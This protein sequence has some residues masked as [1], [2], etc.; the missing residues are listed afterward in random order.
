[1]PTNSDIIYLT[2]TLEL[3]QIRRGFCAPNPSVGAII[4]RDANM[5]ATGYHYAP[6]HPHA[7]IDALKKINHQ[8]QGATLYVSLEPCCHHGRT[9]PCTDAIIQAGI[10]RVVYG[11]C[12]PNPLVSDKGA[13]ALNSAGISCEYLPLQQINEFYKSY[14]HWT[15]TKTPFITGKIA[16]SLDGKIA[17]KNGA[18]LQITGSELKEFTHA[19]RK[20]SDAILT[21]SNTIIKDNPQLNVRSQNETLSKPIYILDSQLNLPLIAQ[22]FT[23]AKTITVFHSKNAGDEKLKALTQ[24]GVRCISVEANEQGLNLNQIIQFIGQDGAHDLWIEA[25][26]KCFAAFAKERLLQ[27]AYL[28]I[29]PIILGEGLLAFDS[30]IEFSLTQAHWKQFG[31]DVLCELGLVDNLSLSS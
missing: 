15:Q 1:M 3:A 17:G 5:L 11:Y 20:T 13:E 23:T 18:P 10:K 9:P 16:L 31:K 21:T 24:Q 26:G 25:G 14:H 7:E 29:A 30:K 22:I 2:Q 8:A 12:D 27:R 6:G 28:Y 19:A 4:V